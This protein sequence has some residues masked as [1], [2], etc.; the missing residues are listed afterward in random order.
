V[1][2]GDLRA[3]QTQ[4]TSIPFVNDTSQRETILGVSLRTDGRRIKSTISPSRALSPGQLQSLQTLTHQRKPQLAAPA[5]ASAGDAGG[6]PCESVL[7]ILPRSR[8]EKLFA[9]LVYLRVW[10]EAFR[11]RTFPLASPVGTL[12]TKQ[13]RPACG[14]VGCFPA[15]ECF[16]VCGPQC[17]PRAASVNGLALAELVHQR[18]GRPICEAAFSGKNR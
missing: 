11:R 12:R 15:W 17:A 9:R 16:G 4:F 8:A 10:A 18:Q 3:Y 1:R 5:P 7:R 13:L 2:R 14:G 6:S